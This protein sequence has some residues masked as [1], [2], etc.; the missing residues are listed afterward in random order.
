MWLRL[1]VVALLVVVMAVRGG[2]VA[3]ASCAGGFR[4]LARDAAQVFVGTVTAERLGHTQ[5]RVEQVWRGPDLA[6]QVWL[7]SGT[8]QAPWPLRL[9]VRVGGSADVDLAT[10]QRYVV[11]M[12]GDR[13]R[14]NDC[15]VSEADRT[16]IAALAP[17]RTREPVSS[18]ATGARPPLSPL[19]LNVAGLVVIAGLLVLGVRRARRTTR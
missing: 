17:E 6:P 2:E 13:F 12:E 14:T 9:V 3:M 11:A 15:L 8:P 16:L 7:L 19:V 10:G 18:G 5:F 4:P 1:V